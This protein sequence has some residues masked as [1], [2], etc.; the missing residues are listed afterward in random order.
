MQKRCTKCG[1]VLPRAAFHA[2][3][4]H[5]PNAVVPACKECIND[6]RAARRA[7]ADPVVKELA[8]AK[9]RTWKRENRERNRAKKRAWEIANPEKVRAHGRKSSAKIRAKDPQLAI[10]RSLA[11]RA[12]NPEAFKIYNAQW[13]KDNAARCRAKY[14]RYMALKE[15]RVPAWANDFFMEEAYE[16]AQLRTSMLGYPW[17]VDHTVPMQS[18]NVCG[19]HVHDN[20]QVIPGVENLSKGNKRWPNMWA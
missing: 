2:R 1:R 3:P 4:Y 6:S 16:L 7:N 15:S 17:H 12:K 20:L 9:A 10:A 14:K 13:Q 8:L 18:P 19:L 5:S 11:S